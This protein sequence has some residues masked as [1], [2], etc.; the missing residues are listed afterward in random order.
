MN[1]K[2]WY[3]IKCITYNEY[4]KQRRKRREP[5]IFKEIM[6]ENILYLMKNN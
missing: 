2:L 3:V 4:Q 6:A 1:G 5:N